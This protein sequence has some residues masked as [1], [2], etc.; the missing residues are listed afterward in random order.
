MP[1]EETS[2]QAFFNAKIKDRGIS[3]KKLSEATGIAQAHLEN[4]INGKFDDLPSAPYVRGYMVRLGKALDFDGEAWWEKIK[5]EGFSKKSG[6]EDALPKNR[7]IKQSRD[8]FIGVGVV[9]LIIII[10]LGF[11]IPVIF[12]KPSITVTFPS[13]NPF[14]TSSSTLTIQGT[15]S[16]ANSL[17][18][19]GDT[20][21]INPDGSWQKT[22]LLQSQN[23]LN[24]FKI[25]A[26]KLLGGETDL[27]EQI[28]Y[29]DNGLTATSTSGATSTAS[30]SESTNGASTTAPKNP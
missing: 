5:R 2:F 30:S 8:R 6:P 23:G 12:S 20:I 26:S 4:M 19:N 16:N 28:F 22:V 29:Q 11:Q 25:T 24:N 13:Q 15:V 21:T 3:L 9:I 17:S 1:P 27:T 18:L 10:Y 7:F 14:T